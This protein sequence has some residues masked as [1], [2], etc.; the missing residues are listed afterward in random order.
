MVFP[1][2]ACRWDMMKEEA[3]E[4]TARRILQEGSDPVVR[5]RL[6]RDVLKAPLDTDTFANAR[7]EMLRSRWILELK[8]EQ[9]EDGSWGRFHSA[10][11]T[12]GKIGTT[13]AAVERGLA[14]GLGAFDPIFQAAV[15][16]L[17]RLLEGTIDFPD[18]P[19]RNNRWATGKTL[20]VAATLARICPTLPILDRTRE[21]WTTIARE[22]FNSGKYDPEA[23]TRAHQMLTG[24]SVKDSYLVLNSRYQLALIGSRAKKLSRTLENALVDWVWHKEDG[25]GY[26]EIPL[27]NRPQRFTPSMFDR[28]FTSLELLSHFPSWRKLAGNV[29]DWLWGQRNQAGFW[30]FGPRASMSCYFPL[31]GSWPKKHD[32]QHDWSVRVLALLRNYYGH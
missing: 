30:D 31:S 8:N 16:Y 28:L 25:V 21:L 22:T 27:S 23:E 4:E 15:D 18:P 1:V 29:V 24:A 17:S 32:Q 19:E 12:K 26:L 5:F 6:L 20:F 10:I 13:E 14:L 7:Q 11:K 2:G 3:I 9:K